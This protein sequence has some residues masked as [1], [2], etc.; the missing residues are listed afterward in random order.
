MTR[1]DVKCPICLAI[2][3]A[4]DLDNHVG[5]HTTLTNLPIEVQQSRFTVTT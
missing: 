1:D 4:C 3:E 2:V 5:W